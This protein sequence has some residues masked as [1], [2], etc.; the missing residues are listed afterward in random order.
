ML[1]R[2]L[3]YKISLYLFFR[4]NTQPLTHLL[5]HLHPKISKTSNFREISS[6]KH[7]GKK[8][9]DISKLLSKSDKGGIIFYG[10]LCMNILNI[11]FK[12]EKNFEFP[13]KLDLLNWNGS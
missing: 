8:D 4:K 13:Q 12:P 2:I 6:E 11:H 10:N 5:N 3:F 9:I 1:T 7:R